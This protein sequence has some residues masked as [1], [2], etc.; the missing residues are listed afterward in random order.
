MGQER[1]EVREKEV[2][3]ERR[4]EGVEGYGERRMGEERLK[5]G[6]GGVRE[7]G[8]QSSERGRER[9]GEGQREREEDR[10]EQE[11]EG[12]T[13]KGK[14][15]EGKQK[16]KEKGEEKKVE[17][18]KKSARE[19]GVLEDGRGKGWGVLVCEGR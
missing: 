1:Q 10:E 7:K 14:V 11:K 17:E 4:G 13:K 3:G 6:N 19:G 12:D 9:G 5:G 16:E 2:E 18:G 8:R 15:E